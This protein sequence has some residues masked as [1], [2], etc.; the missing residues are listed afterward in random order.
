MHDESQPSLAGTVF[1]LDKLIVPRASAELGRK[2]L[3]EKF[4]QIAV[5]VAHPLTGQLFEAPDVVKV[6][7]EPSLIQSAAAGSFFDPPVIAVFYVQVKA[8]KQRR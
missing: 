6:K 3:L 2:N 4:I 8:R 7:R 1:F 5:G